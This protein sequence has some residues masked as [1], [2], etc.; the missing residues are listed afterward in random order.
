MEQRTIA[1]RYALIEQ[2]G[3]SSWRATDTELEREVLVRLPAGEVGPTTLAHPNIVRVFDQGEEDGERYAVLEYLPGGSLDQRLAAG[4]LSEAEARGVAADVEAALAYA[5]AQGVTHGSL[6]PASVLL[7][8]EGR[9]K[10]VGFTGGAEPEGDLLAFAALLQILGVNT[11]AGPEPDVTQVLQAPPAAAS[12]RPLVLAPVAVL[13]LLAA[14]VAAAFLATS[15]GSNPDGATPSLSLQVPTGSTG[16]TGATTQEPADSQPATTA[17]TTTEE[18]TTASTSGPTTTTAPA[19]TSAPPPATTAPPP[20]TEPPPPPPPPTTTEP[21][22][23][24]TTE[25]PPPS[26]GTPTE[27]SEGR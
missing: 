26:T 8:A 21:P 3:D 17:E 22:P 27:T 20:T 5:H 25:P 4:P 13:A 11:L 14:G 24:P 12:R 23:P 9:A 1:G 2:I 19:T 16:S 15:G 18:T 10:V 7:D 6:G